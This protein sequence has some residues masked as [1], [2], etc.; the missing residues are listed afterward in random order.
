MVAFAPA[1]S[2]ESRALEERAGGGVVYRM[3]GSPGDRPLS[4]PDAATRRSGA[5]RGV[6]ATRAPALGEAAGTMVSTPRPA[7]R[8]PRREDPMD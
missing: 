7:A 3:L 5:E 6:A 1:S 4:I 8:S 2:A